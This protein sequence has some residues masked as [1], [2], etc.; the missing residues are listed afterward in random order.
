MNNTFA[1]WAQYLMDRNLFI[2]S[3]RKQSSKEKW[4][5]LSIDGV[6]GKT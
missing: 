6:G 2:I 5:A 1:W 3:E 4:E